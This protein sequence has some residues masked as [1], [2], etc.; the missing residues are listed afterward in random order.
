MAKP[1]RIEEKG[2][3]TF[4]T[5]MRH[6][7]LPDFPIGIRDM[8]NAFGACLAYIDW[9]N[10]TRSRFQEGSLIPANGTTASFGLH[11]CLAS[12][13]EQ[14]E[15]ANA[16]P[17][18]WLFRDVAGIVTEIKSRTY[19]L[20]SR[21]T[22]GYDEVNHFATALYDMQ[23]A[24]HQATKASPFVL[25]NTCL[26][27]LHTHLCALRNALGEAMSDIAESNL[28]PARPHSFVIAPQVGQPTALGQGGQK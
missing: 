19:P 12:P 18:R 23:L 15:W 2:F 25:H 13:D 27:A 8:Q 11:G 10:V 26:T 17:L 24:V 28:P 22:V 14:L 16:M 1:A 5:T 3:C 6:A 20:S 4:S 7:L 9:T 21:P